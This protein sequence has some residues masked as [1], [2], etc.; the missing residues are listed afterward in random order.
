MNTTALAPNI[1]PRRGDCENAAQLQNQA[2][3][4]TKIEAN[5]DAMDEP[6]LRKRPR[7]AFD[8]DGIVVMPTAAECRELAKSY[9]SQ[10]NECGISPRR[11]ALLRNIANSLSGLA[12]QLEMLAADATKHS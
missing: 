3:N 6:A 11:A 5:A 2:S 8:L 12:S 9:R 7:S 1:E 4:R 10:A